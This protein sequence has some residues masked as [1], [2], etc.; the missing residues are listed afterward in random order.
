MLDGEMQC[1]S[2]LH[3]HLHKYKYEMNIPIGSYST[4]YEAP[5]RPPSS[6]SESHTEIDI[7][8]F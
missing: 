1:T 5:P 7:R 6:A 2:D 8:L 3:L 4:P